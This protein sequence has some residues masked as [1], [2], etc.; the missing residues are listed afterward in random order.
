MLLNANERSKKKT[1]LSFVCAVMVL[2]I[3]S[4]N[5]AQYSLNLNSLF[6]KTVYF[7]ETV[8][9]ENITMVAV[10]LFFFLS[11]VFFFRNYSWDK[12]IDKYRSRIKSLLIPY[13][14]WNTFYVIAAFLFS[15]LPYVS[16]RVSASWKMNPINF[17]NMIEGLFF[18]KYHAVY[19]FLFQLILFIA[20]SPVLFSILKNS[21]LGVTAL[22]ILLFSPVY[23]QYVAVI[24]PEHLFYFLLGGYLGYHYFTVFI[25]Y[26]IN[27]IKS[28]AVIAGFIILF[29]IDKI[30]G[31]NQIWHRVVIVAY[32]FALMYGLDLFGKIQTTKYMSHTFFIYSSH[33]F[34][35][36][37]LKLFFRKLLP[38]TDLFAFLNFLLMPIIALVFIISA[39]SLLDRNFP[40]LFKILNGGR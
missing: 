21:I 27:K 8:L 17:Q 30:T 3:H 13:L 24:N 33:L 9:L 18:Y 16:A 28:M 32:I 31:T 36:S 25:A 29:M 5:T 7:I 38:E 19:W 4:D 22:I 39:A 12:V 20:I 6:G 11:G 14:V 35:L 1:I 10:P 34:V 37:M 40:K 26:Q 23:S 2:Y 15:V